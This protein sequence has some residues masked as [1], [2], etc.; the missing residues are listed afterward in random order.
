[1]EKIRRSVLVALLVGSGL[2]AI[3]IGPARADGNESSETPAAAPDL[4][5]GTAHTCTVLD[6]ATVKCWGSGN[7]GRLGN[8]STI[9]RGDNPGEMAALVPVDLGTG[10]TAVAVA[11]GDEHTCAILD[12]GSVKCW[13]NGANGRLG[14]DNTTTQG[15]SP[16]DMAALPTVDLGAGRTA[17]A[18]TAGFAHTCVLLDNHTV[19]C[20]GHGGGGRLGYDNTTDQGDTAGDMA[21]L[22]AV[23]LGAGRTAV[24][25]SAG[26]DHTCAILDSGQVKCWG[27]GA[28]GRL[29]YDN[30]TDQGDTAGDMAALPAVNLGANRTALAISAGFNHTCAVLDNH[31]VKC[32]GL[33]TNGRLGLDNTTTQGDTVGDMAI[34]PSVNLGPGRTALAVTTGF[35]H[36]CVLLDTDAV[37]CWGGGA[38]GQL[39]NDSTTN[40]GDSAGEMAALPS[41]DLGDGRT[42]LAVTAGDNSTCA[43]LDNHRVKCWGS[44]NSGRL[45]YDNSISQGDSAGD[46]AAL[47]TVNLGSG[48]TLGPQPGIAASVSADEAA[49]V[50]GATIHYD[51]TITNTRGV[52]L[53]GIEVIAPDAA[54]CEQPVADLAPGHVA[55]I[56]CSYPTTTADIPQMTNQVLVTTDQGVVALSGNRRT[57]VDPQV[58]RPDAQLQLGTGAFVGDSAYNTSGAGQARSATVPNR[59]TATFTLR[60]QN[61]GNVADDITV[62]GLGSTSRF[63]VTY[64]DGPVDITAAVVAGTHT[65]DG[66]LPGALHDLTVTIKA[67]NG[68]PVNTVINRLVTVTSAG[69]P[70]QKDAVKAGVKR[71]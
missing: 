34:L 29:G 36:T 46:M 6:N 15:D 22:P 61:D 7:L 66:L 10:H 25:I 39:G 32:W 21:A 20:W 60:V 9:P 68:T 63:T 58:F 41:V 62:K 48:R 23:N 28:N 50:A 4:T 56:V 40:Q 65:L 55:A 42:A 18:I 14:Y 54:G 52:R 33:G 35:T 45:G 64:K 5:V 11:A 57:R 13:G 31:T 16:G 2:A 53:T 3:A 71:R 49:V 51:V 30:T 70:A 67:K 24:A 47:P 44:G 1:M 37:K 27:L 59:G 38:S 19:K 12:D 69:D 43:V 17:L 8:D 26:T